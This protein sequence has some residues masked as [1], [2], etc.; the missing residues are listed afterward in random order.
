MRFIAPLVLLGTG[1]IV[2]A[3]LGLAPG[4]AKGGSDR[5]ALDDG[6]GGGAD[7]ACV[8]PAPPVLGV[9]VFGDA[10]DGGAPTV[11]WSP[12]RRVSRLEYDNMVRDLVGDTTHPASTFVQESGMATGINLQTNTYGGV[13]EL[14]AQQYLLAAEGVAKTAVGAGADG[15]ASNLDNVFALN[16]IAPCETQDAACALQFLSVFAKRAFRGHLEATEASAL[17]DIYTA[18]AEGPA[19]NN[20][21]FA[22]GIQAVITA[23]LSSPYF[24]YVVE[25]G[26]GSAQ[27]GGAVPLSQYE[28]AARLALFLWRTVPDVGPGSLMAAAAAGTLS[29]PA[30]IQAQA[31]RMLADPKAFDA[32][33][34]FTTQWM[35]IQAPPSG[36]DTVFSAWTNSPAPGLGV[37]MK[38]ETLTNV[39]QLVLVENGS[40]TELLTSP[41][42]YVNADLARFYGATAG[43]GTAVTV[44]DPALTGAGQ[45]QFVQTTLP[46]RA[47]LLTNGS[48]LAIQSHAL[49]PSS[50]LR[51]KLIREDVLCDAIQPPPPG[52]PAVASSVADGGTTRSLFQAHAQIG[53]TTGPGVFC[54]GC[55]QYMD[56]LGF[57]MGHY[58][59]TGAYQAADQNGAPTGP[60]LDATGQIFSPQP[61]ELT[62]TF[63][64]A[65]D[66]TTGMVAELAGSAQVQECFA[67]QEFRYSL[68][69]V[70]TASD[71]CSLQQFYGA[72]T[73]GGLNVQKLILGI[74]G[75]DAF[76][77]RSAD[78]AGAACS[79]ATAGSSCQ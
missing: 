61:G 14:I 71:S 23:V 12:M 20:F 37:E 24:F 26:D 69:R 63:N 32:V 21:G 73:S 79:A 55:H 62:A 3:A 16:G 53:G 76:R 10:C 41:A 44:A 56:W 42:S 67:L 58:D 27:A 50:V 11:D 31:V 36:K 19:P 25:M 45:T 72:F 39:S 8:P 68:G 65:T 18:I 38:D 48:T 34:D 64:G 15:G 43:A 7:G 4:C 17:L 1:M 70:E 35:E 22:V 30:Q 46:N 52:V 33:N 5:P 9:S 66:P 78:V 40:L 74:V 6:G 28:I 59:A 49:L 2:G 47:G 51:G 77:Y 54:Y 57:G 75:S 13:S 29:T 60:P